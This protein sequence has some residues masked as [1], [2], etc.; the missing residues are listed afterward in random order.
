[1]VQSDRSGQARTS[2]F[3]VGDAIARFVPSDRDLLAGG[4]G[5]GI[6]VEVDVEVVF[7]VT[8]AGSDWR[9]GLAAAVDAGSGQMVQ[10]LPA[11]IGGVPI[12]LR[13]G[14]GRRGDAGA[15]PGHWPAGRRPVPA[16]ATWAAALAS[17]SPVGL[18][19]AFPAPGPLGFGGRLA[20]TAVADGEIL[21]FR[22]GISAVT[23]SSPPVRS[24]I[25]SAATEASPTLAAL[26]SV[27]VMISESGSTAML[28]LYPSKPRAEVLCPWRASGSTVEI[29]RSGA[30]RRAIREHPVLVLL[31]VLAQNRRQQFGRIS[32]GAFEF[33]GYQG[34]PEWRSRRVAR[35]WISS[36]RAA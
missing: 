24:S 7:A 17:P 34:A 11:A 15:G 23:G 14:P 25:R 32:Q 30:T 27:S 29:T 28:P 22:A 16:R 6:G 36:S 26:T 18:A 21:A 35:E 5:D 4:A 13:A 1:M 10:E 8:P 31:Q 9:L 19:G 20:A 12:D 33:S 2:R 3:E